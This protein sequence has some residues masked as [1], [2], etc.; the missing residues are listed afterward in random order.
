MFT[1]LIHNWISNYLIHDKYFFINDIKM[2]TK[3]KKIL[4]FITFL[5][6]FFCEQ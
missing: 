1:F 6:S 3:I 2:N 5:K 4:S